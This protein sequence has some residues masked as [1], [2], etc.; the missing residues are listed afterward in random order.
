MYGKK[1]LRLGGEIS[2]ERERPLGRLRYRWEG[3]IKMVL[4]NHEGGIK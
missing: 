4:Q 3:N 2:R 1:S